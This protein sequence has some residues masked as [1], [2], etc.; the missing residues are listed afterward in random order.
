MERSYF[1]KSM[2]E[3][4]EKADES[5][6]FELIQASEGSSLLES[7]KMAW[8]VQVSLLKKQLPKALNGRVIFEYTIPR[9][10][11]RVDV[12]LVLSHAI[13]VIEFKVNAG[14]FFGADKDQ[15][16]DYALDLKNFHETSH[17]CLL[18]PILVATNASEQTFEL[19][20]NEDSISNILL[21]NG[22]NLAEIIKKTADNYTAVA[23]PI[24]VLGWEH[25]RYKPTPTIIEAARALYEGHSGPRHFKK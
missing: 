19:S 13:F 25:G 3:F 9:V 20:V 24:D 21:S 18:V 2:Q 4:H 15:T 5:I 6:L 16:I 7:Q 1:S 17:S 11:K 22:L 8:E 12:L 10:G 23:K 14:S